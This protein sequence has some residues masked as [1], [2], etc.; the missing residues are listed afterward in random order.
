[1]ISEHGQK[2]GLLMRRDHGL[3]RMVRGTVAGNWPPHFPLVP[4][5]FP[6]GARKGTERGARKHV[7]TPSRNGRTGT[8]RAQ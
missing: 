1:M 3:S 2:P 6:H 8:V 4:L 7:G 5:P